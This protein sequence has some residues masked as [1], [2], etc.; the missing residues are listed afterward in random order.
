VKESVGSSREPGKPAAS[1]KSAASAEETKPG[2]RARSLPT[3]TFYYTFIVF[4]SGV[5][6]IG[7]VHDEAHREKVEVRHR[8]TLTRSY[9][10]L[11]RE[12]TLEELIAFSPLYGQFMRQHDAKPADAGFGATWYDAVRFCRWLGQQSGLPERDQPYAAPETLDKSKYR[13]E[14]NPA[15]SWAPRNWPLELGRRGFRLPTETEWEVACRAGAR[16]SYGFG[17]DVSLLGR[18][19]W[20]AENSGRHGRPPRELRPSIRGLFDLHGNLLEWTHDWS[21]D[22]GESALVDPLGAKEG[23]ARVYR[24]GS[25]DFDSA[26]CRTAYRYAVDPTFYASYYGFRLALSL[27]E[28][29]PEAAS[30]KAAGPSGA[31]T[32]RASAEHR[33]NMP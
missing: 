3:K 21:G 7:S 26:Y 32:E 28:V 14:P 6:D 30:F 22:F 20:F 18:F 19:G 13:R 16:T 25:W 11:D 23:P 27:S 17:S 33:A 4:T 5:Y 9:A 24:G 31:G 29:T 10:L 12:I 1:S 2:R 15:A 8:I